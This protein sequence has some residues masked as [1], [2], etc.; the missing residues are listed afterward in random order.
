MTRLARLASAVLAAGLLAAWQAPALACACDKEARI[1][2]YGTL[3][4]ERPAEPPS[5]PAV[6]LE[7][8][9]PVPAA[10]S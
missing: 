9:P 8:P 3:R 5:T 10:G 4:L 2:K 6:P 1:K 7:P